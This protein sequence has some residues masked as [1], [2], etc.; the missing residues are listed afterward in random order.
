MD[1]QDHP[2]S[3]YYSAWSG[4]WTE[5]LLA[6]DASMDIRVDASTIVNVHATSEQAMAPTWED[7]IRAQGSG[8]APE[9]QPLVPVSLRFE[10]A[11]LSPLGTSV[12]QTLVWDCKRIEL[13]PHPDLWRL[14]ELRMDPGTGNGQPVIV[15]RSA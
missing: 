7:G 6:A 1:R 4:R 8:Q 10:F 13:R 9:R 15:R 14:E 11:Y 5:P 3:D 12:T 2:E